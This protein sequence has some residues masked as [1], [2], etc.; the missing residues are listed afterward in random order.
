MKNEYLKNVRYIK[1]IL[2]GRIKTVHNNLQKEMNNFA[3]S[4]N[5]EEAKL[6]KDKIRRLEYITRPAIMNL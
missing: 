6:T 2:S 1:G 3:E 4:E 5:F